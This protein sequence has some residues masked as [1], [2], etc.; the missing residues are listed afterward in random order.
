[1]KTKLRQFGDRGEKL[2]EN[3]LRKKGYEVLEKNWN[4]RE[5][6]IDLVARKNNELIFVEVKTRQSGKFGS[7]EEA[8]SELKLNKIITA[9]EKYLLEKNY[10]ENVFWRVDV[11]VIAE[12]DSVLQV[13]SHLENVTI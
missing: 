6:E 12:K 10:S 2:A 11:I 1:M 4:C 13:I 3:F 7:G 5:G 9:C 8:V